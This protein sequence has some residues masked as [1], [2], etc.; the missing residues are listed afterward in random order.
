LLENIKVA[1]RF[2]AAEILGSNFATQVASDTLVIDI[3]NAGKIFWIFFWNY[4]HE[5]VNRISPPAL[6]SIS[7]SRLGWGEMIGLRRLITF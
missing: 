3:V 7:S 5:R 2:F 4:A 1:L 6:I